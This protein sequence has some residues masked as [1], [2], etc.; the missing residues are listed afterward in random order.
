M[1]DNTKHPLAKHIEVAGFRMS[2]KPGGK[3]T[4]KMVVINHSRADVSDLGLDVKT[5]ACT[6]SVKVPAL[7]PEESKEV[8]GECTTQLRVYE[9]PDWM[10]VRP[11]FTI[12]A[13]P[14]G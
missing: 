13:P 6:V 4:V 3:L 1:A 8:T 12:T 9:L 2:E 14:E 5:P 7:A 11:T 10:F